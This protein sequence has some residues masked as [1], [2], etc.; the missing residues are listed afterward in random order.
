MQKLQNCGFDVSI[1]K[2]VAHR[3]DYLYEFS[4]DKWMYNGY[5]Y[6]Q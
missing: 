3:R 6:A 2:P 4:E 1:T 5:I